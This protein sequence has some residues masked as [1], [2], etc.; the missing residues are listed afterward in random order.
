M[1][2]F[3]VLSDVL[4]EINSKQDVDI[5]EEMPEQTTNG[6]LKLFGILKYKPLGKAASKRTFLGFGNWNKPV[7]YP[8]RHWLLQMNDELQRGGAYIFSS[9]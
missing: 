3:E 5:R 2:L 1:R 9:F 6:I 4:A 8:L 7:I